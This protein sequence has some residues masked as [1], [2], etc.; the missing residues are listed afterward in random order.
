MRTGDGDLGDSGRAGLDVKDAV[1]ASRA[2]AYDGRGGDGVRSGRYAQA[3]AASTPLH[4]DPRAVQRHVEIVSAWSGRRWTTKACAASLANLQVVL[5]IE[6]ECVANDDAAAGAEGKPLDVRILREV[7]GQAVHRAIESNRRIADREPADPGGRGYISLDECGRDAKHIGDVVEP[8]RGV[9]WWQQRADIDVE[10]EE[11]A[12]RVRVFRSIETMERRRAG[13]G[14]AHRRSIERGFERDGE[15][16]TRRCRRLRR[17][18]GR[19]HPGAQLADDFLPCL[20]V[21]VHGLGAQ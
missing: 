8:G 21:T 10:R 15:R 19:H 6:R 12:H 14:M 9:V 20:R 18:L 5:G 3:C 16:L 11:I 7:A 17:V 4:R 2:R 13:I 1:S